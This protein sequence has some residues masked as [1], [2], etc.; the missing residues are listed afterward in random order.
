MA[1]GRVAFL[2]ETKAALE[3]FKRFVLRNITLTS[4][5]GPRCKKTGL[6]GF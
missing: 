4:T 3:F 5:C 1:E 6:R 2:G